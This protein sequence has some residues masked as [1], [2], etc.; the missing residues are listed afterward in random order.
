MSNDSKTKA[1]VW[2][3][4]TRAEAAR[5]VGASRES[6]IRAAEEKGLPAVCDENG[7]FWLVPADLDAWQWRNKAPSAAQKVRVIRE[8]TKARHKEA[9]ERRWKVD[10]AEERSLAEWDAQ[11]ERDR[12]YDEEATALRAATQQKNKAKREA[13][14]DIHMDERTAGKALD[15]DSGAARGVL[16]DLVNRGLLRRVESPGEMR[17]EVSF[18]GIAQE[19][20]SRWP[21]CSGGP[22]YVREDVMEVRR[23][24]IAAR[25]QQPQ[26]AAP[27]E[28]TSG[29][30][31][32]LLALLILLAKHAQKKKPPE[33]E[34]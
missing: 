3:K 6:T 10:A 16:R 15:L 23:Q 14:E 7:Q 33:S 11:R 34:D 8:A 9:G 12:K 4:F 1:P 20:E 19:I 30:L 17:V 2:L 28:P 5:Y 13:F 21:L 24:M 27:K 32:A 29:D 22:F 18:E 26:T 31:V 25:Q